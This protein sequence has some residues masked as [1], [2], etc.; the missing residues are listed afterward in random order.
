[1]SPF[2]ERL[3]ANLEKAVAK[4]KKKC[5]AEAC[6]ENTSAEVDAKVLFVKDGTVVEP[7]LAAKVKDFVFQVSCG[8]I[9]TSFDFVISFARKSP[10]SCIFIRFDV[11]ICFIHL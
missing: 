1:M 8:G 9:G 3:N 6:V 4:K 10:T 7:D 2:L 11:Q 5:K